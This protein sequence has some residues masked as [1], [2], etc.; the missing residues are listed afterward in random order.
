MA[1]KLNPDAT[2]NLTYGTISFAICFAAWG[3]VSAFASEFRRE[4]G[5]TAQSTA[6]L[7]AVPV[8]L[9]SLARLPMGML[10][11]RFGGRLVFTVLF[12]LVGAAAAD[13][14]GTGGR[15]ADVERHRRHGERAAVGIDGDMAGTPEGIDHKLRIRAN[16]VDAACFGL[17]VSFNAQLDR[18]IEEVEILLDFADRTEALI[19]A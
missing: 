5:L 6:F 10:T 11:D 15:A 14:L 13:L 9:G 19:V 18:H 4:L 1:T 2:R 12:F 3:L 8:L 17:A 16:H 7:V